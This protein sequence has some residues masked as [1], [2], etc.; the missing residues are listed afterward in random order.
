MM[1][2]AL[3]QGKKE[4]DE[5]WVERL[6]REMSEFYKDVKIDSTNWSYEISTYKKRPMYLL[7]RDNKDVDKKIGF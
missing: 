5:D 2:K 3:L 4:S 6:A 1:F 7:K